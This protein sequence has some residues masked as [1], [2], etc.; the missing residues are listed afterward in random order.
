MPETSTLRTAV[1]IGLLIFCLGCADSGPSGGG[2]GNGGG[3]DVFEPTSDVQLSGER[4]FRRVRIPVGVTVRASDDLRLIAMEELRVEGSIVGDCVELEVRGGSVELV[5]V[6]QNACSGTLPESPPPLTIRSSGAIDVLRTIIRSSGEVSVIGATGGSSGLA[7]AQQPGCVLDGSLMEAVPQDAAAASG[8]ASWRISCGGPVEMAG[9]TVRS[10]NGGVAGESASGQ[11]VVIGQ[12][13][14]A[15]GHIRVTGQT[16]RF[17]GIN[18]LLAGDGAAGAD[19]EAVAADPGEDAEATAGD[20]GAAGG[21][22]I[23]SGGAIEVAGPLTLELGA[24]GDGGNAS[25]EAAPG[26]DGTDTAPAEDGGSAVAIAGTGGSVPAVELGESSVS[27]ADNVFI[28]AGDA[29]DGGLALARAGDGGDGSP[30]FPPGAAGGTAEAVGG[31]GGSSATTGLSGSPVSRAGEGGEI[32]LTGANGGRGASLCPSVSDPDAP[33]D[34]GG[35]GGPGGLASG[36]DGRPG[37]SGT[38]DPE[39]GGGALFELARGGHGGA[40]SPPGPGGSAGTDATDIEGTVVRGPGIFD[41]GDPGLPCGLLQVLN[42]TARI[43]LQANG[44]PAGLDDQIFDIPAGQQNPNQQPTGSVQHGVRIVASEDRIRVEGSAPWI[45]VEGDLEVDGTFR[46]EGAGTVAGS[47]G[48][49]VLE[50]LFINGGLSSTLTL[51]VEGGASVRYS[52]ISPQLLGSI[53]G[54]GVSTA[55]AE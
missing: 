37:S 3:G 26:A 27:G 15:G 21:I 5:G 33:T 8:G 36:R 43:Q 29:G 12:D 25:A 30:A 38:G 7:P 20:G 53:T 50:G 48:T 49:A 35:A 17:S 44:D 10:Q 45:D 13:G 28:R 18:V 9:T 34:A 42:V 23:S 24:G 19:V 55:E 54:A 32:V 52:V 46:A 47:P 31:D 39:P 14:G 6:V 4:T 2:G 1:P 11:A 22:E 40:G 16:I 41:P 51:T